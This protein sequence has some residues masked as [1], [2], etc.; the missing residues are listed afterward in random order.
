MVS[1]RQ[2]E[3]LYTT[4]TCFGPVARI[5][6]QSIDADL[7]SDEY[8]ADVKNYLGQVDRQI[9]SFVG[10]GGYKSLEQATDEGA[11]HKIVLMDP[12]RRATSFQAR[13]I[14]KYIAHRMV[15]VFEEKQQMRCYELFKSLSK[16][17]ALRSSAG[18]FFEAYAHEWL[19]RGGR[20]EAD[21]LP[22]SNANAEPLSFR[23]TAP[24]VAGTGHFTTSKDLAARVRVG[25]GGQGIDARVHEIY[26]QPY[27]KTQESFDGL[28]FIDSHTLVLVQFT[29][30]KTH[31][32][33][34]RG[35]KQLLHELPATINT[36]C[37]VFVV[38]G[39]RA[40]NYSN[41][42][43]VPTAASITSRRGVKV[44]QYRLVFPDR[45][46]EAVAL[47]GP[48]S[49]GDGDGT[50]VG[51]DGGYEDD[52]EDEGEDTGEGPRDDAGDVRMSSL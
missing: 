13:V 44:K 22:V 34:S 32:I 3:A 48:Q 41:E 39:E 28:L 24:R 30:A 8:E 51:G 29:L 47:Q 26:F 37:I 45:D 20:F 42:Q 4:F 7:G 36:V 18:W 25:S 11:S 15:A 46:I 38:P 16:T 23:T 27:T 43:K 6:L 12:N 33:K 52:N 35:V 2:T 5:C 1:T 50:E 14:T 49:P 31:E 9:E 40:D 17:P 21:E 19:G 10:Q